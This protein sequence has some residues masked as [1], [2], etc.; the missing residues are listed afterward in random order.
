M[1]WLCRL[2]FDARMTDCLERRLESSAQFVPD[3]GHAP[4]RPV[5]WSNSRSISFGV[6]K[7]CIDVVCLQATHVQLNTAPEEFDS[8]VRIAH[9]CGMP[10]PN[11]A[12]LREALDRLGQSVPEV[13]AIY[14]RD[15][16]SELVSYRA[17]L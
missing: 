2:E 14:S 7:G 9:E 17:F 4:S 3:H 13:L 12:A 8:L 15:T 16:I 5:W 6:S 11:E 10:E 1:S